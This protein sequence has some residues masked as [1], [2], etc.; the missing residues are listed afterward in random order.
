MN[1]QSFMKSLFHGV[2]AENVIFPYPEPSNG[3][4]D[5]LNAILE[6]VRRFCA[7]NVDSAKIDEEQA[8]PAAVLEGL[9]ALGLFGMQIPKELGGMGLSN[10]G[11]ARVMQEISG[12]DPSIALTLGGHQSIGIKGLLLFGTDEQK[13]KYLPRLA[14]GELVAAFALTEPSAGSDAA[15]IQ[16]RADRHPRHN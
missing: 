15:A 5:S 8:I 1:D 11:Y 16:T 6:N 2:I 13:K 3:E 4:A 14:T 12:I 10:T 9:K 7:A